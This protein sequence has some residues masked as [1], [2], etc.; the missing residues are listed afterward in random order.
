VTGVQTCALPIWRALDADLAGRATSDVAASYGLDWSTADGSQAFDNLSASVAAFVRP[1]QDWFVGFSISRNSRAPTEF[2]LFADGP[3]AGTGSYEVGNPALSSEEV[4]S[5]EL[6]LRWTGSR[7]SVE[8]H[9]YTADYDGFIQ[10]LPTG[11]TVDEDGVLDPAGEFPVFRYGQAD[12]TFSGLELEGSH[13]LWRDGGRSLTLEG[14]YDY[15]R[16]ETDAGA[17]ARIPSWSATTRLVWKGDRLDGRLEVRQVGDQDRVAAYELPTDGYTMVN[18]QIGFKPFADRD[19]TL[20]L[21]GRN[22][23]DVEAREHTSFLK[24][25]A[26]LP[27]RSLRVGLT[28]DF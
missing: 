10:E 27:G 23:G 17:P 13:E 5:Y 25:I 24:D 12:A 16:G 11:D 15:V 19:L 9:L 20:F 3:H 1:S 7:S 18:A 21:E 22:L 6:T 14:A 26:P 2:E 28:W 4:T 8:A